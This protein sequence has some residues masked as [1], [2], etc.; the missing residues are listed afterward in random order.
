MCAC[1]AHTG[2]CMY[3]CM[4]AVC[5]RA[6]V[7]GNVSRVSMAFGCAWSLCWCRRGVDAAGGF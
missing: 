4:Y 1:A 2:G 5:V 7:I 6:C 3:A